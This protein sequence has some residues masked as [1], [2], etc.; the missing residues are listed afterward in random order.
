MNEVTQ[1]DKN[2]IAYYIR[3][4]MAQPDTVENKTAYIGTI[5]QADEMVYFCCVWGMAL[6]GL[7]GSA[8]IAR[9]ALSKGRPEL[10]CRTIADAFGVDYKFFWKV[11]ELHI[12]GIAAEE[13]ARRLEAGEI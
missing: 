7:Y 4:G 6:V 8:H 1:E 3:A 9:E 2:R 12:K 5:T 13:I 10:E 11:E